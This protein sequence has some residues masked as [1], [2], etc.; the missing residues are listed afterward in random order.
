MKIKQ[1]PLCYH[2]VK[3]TLSFQKKEKRNLS[4][5]NLKDFFIL[6]KYCDLKRKLKVNQY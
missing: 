3:L 4:H 1:T 6:A 5:I 2:F